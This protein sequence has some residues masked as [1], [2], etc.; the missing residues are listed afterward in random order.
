MRNPNE[1]LTISFYSHP[2]LY[3]TNRAAGEVYRLKS[4]HKTLQKHIQ[5][6]PTP[7]CLSF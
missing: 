7:L 1:T 3:L 4:S 5:G 2:Y 6:A